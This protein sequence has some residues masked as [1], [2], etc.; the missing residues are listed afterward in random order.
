MRQV[1]MA[2]LTFA[3]SG[4]AAAACL[5]HEA[6]PPPLVLEGAYRL[7]SSTRTIVAT[8]EVEDSF[9]S[10]PT[11]YI[12]YGADHRMMV[13]I[14]RAQRP[15]ATFATMTPADKAGL[16]DTMAAYGGTYS[17]DG[18]TVTH[19]IDIS[20]NGILTG[21]DVVRS[22]AVEGDRLIYTTGP[23]PAPT[24]GKISTSKLVWERVRSAPT[25]V[26]QQ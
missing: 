23:G 12:L 1:L 10:Q 25:T 6:T 4:F 7:V 21:T 5:A 19:H 2:A 9:G 14:V 22:V 15:K 11:G 16:F 3:A 18:R 20:W 8:G 24:D 13:L 26:Q 17:F